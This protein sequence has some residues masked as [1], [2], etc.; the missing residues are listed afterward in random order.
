MRNLGAA[1]TFFDNPGARKWFYTI[2]VIIDPHHLTPSGE[3]TVVSDSWAIADY[4]D[5][6]Y[7]TPNLLLPPGT[8]ALQSL[9]DG[10]FTKIVLYILSPTWISTFPTFLNDES[11]P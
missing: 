7:P 9:F 8:K 3:P 6:V 4:L 5:E 1:P 11:R 2:P 10:Y